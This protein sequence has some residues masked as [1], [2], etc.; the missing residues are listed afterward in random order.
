MAANK[1]AHEYHSANLIKHEVMSADR[2]AVV[3]LLLRTKRRESQVNC[4][5]F[6]I[7][8]LCRADLSSA[9]CSGQIPI[10]EETGGFFGARVVVR[11]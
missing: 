3:S 11:G 6:L 10:S 7:M 5:L 8:N 9:E 2:A 4:V 1:P